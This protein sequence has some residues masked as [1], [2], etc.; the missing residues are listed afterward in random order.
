MVDFGRQAWLNGRPFENL[1]RA[2]AHKDPDDV[3]AIIAFEA[4]AVTGEPRP[5]DLL[6]DEIERL[7]AS[8]KFR[9]HLPEIG[10]DEA[11]ELIKDMGRVAAVAVHDNGLVTANAIFASGADRQQIQSEVDAA[12]E[13]IQRQH[14]I[15]KKRER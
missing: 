7:R 2:I 8:P 10:A 12:L 14:R 11:E 4:D 15:V 3:Q 1:A 9:A 6:H 5:D 13:G